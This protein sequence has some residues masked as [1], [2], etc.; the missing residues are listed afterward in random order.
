MLQWFVKEQVEEE[1]STGTIV[2]QLK[3]IGPEGAALFMMDH[4]LGKRE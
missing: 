4:T 3:M 1:A 2:V